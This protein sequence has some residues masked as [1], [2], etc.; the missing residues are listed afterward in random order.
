MSTLPSIERVVSGRMF[1]PESSL[2]DRALTV[3]RPRRASGSMTSNAWWGVCEQAASET[4]PRPLIVYHDAQERE[5]RGRLSVLDGVVVSESSEV[6]LIAPANRTEPVVVGTL[7]GGP[8]T[9][10]SD[11]EPTQMVLSQ[12]HTLRIVTADG[13]PLLEIDAD[14]DGTTLR[15]MQ[16]DVRWQMPGKFAVE[17]ESIELR[18]RRGQF[19]L[20]AAEDDLVARGR[21][22]RL[23]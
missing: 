22:I 7:D 20:E 18:A 21:Y 5:Q 11:V 16:Q 23:N 8:P 9:P 13:L 3:T 14:T 6:L 2:L 10:A 15:W 17:A 12:G 4:D 19:N 1:E